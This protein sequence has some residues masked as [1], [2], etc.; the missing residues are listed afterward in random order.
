MSA[1]L[2]MKICAAKCWKAAVKASIACIAASVADNDELASMDPEVARLRLY[3]LHDQ[4]TLYQN[5]HE[6][7]T[8]LLIEAN[9]PIEQIDS[10]GFVE[11]AYVVHRTMT[12]LQRHLEQCASRAGGGSGG[13]ERP[14]DGS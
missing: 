13:V 3:V 7:L 11:Q 1:E 8:R 14:E 10:V 4:W 9:E 5:K 6:L 12:R 2:T